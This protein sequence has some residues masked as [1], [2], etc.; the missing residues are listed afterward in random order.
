MRFSIYHT[1]LG[2]LCSAVFFV[3]ISPLPSLAANWG[4]S[5][6]RIELG[7]NEK[8]DIV[9]V[10]NEGDENLQV[11]IK[12]SE[13]SQ[14]ADGKDRYSD[15]SGIIYFPKI[16]ILDKNEERII[17]VGIK[18]PATAREKTYRLFVE[19]IPKPKSKEI[20]GITMSTRF[21]VPIFVK[22]IKEEPGGKVERLI[23][24]NG[25][26][27]IGIKNSGNIHFRI[28]S[29]NISGTDAKGEKVFSKEIAGWYLLSGVSRQYSETVPKDICTAIKSLDIE[30]TTD[31]S[32]F[33]GKLDV[34][35]TMCS[36]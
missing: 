12:V 26:L 13:W 31:R 10:S 17:R 35:K 28:A 8:S 30:V 11:Q 19:E 9:K 20:T 34:D 18:L 6:T 3:C 1:P 2:W 25:I 24:S 32:T 7:I 4:V 5:P 29:I 27:N 23:L 22:P 14:D 16:M 15:T 36:P 21:S 33:T